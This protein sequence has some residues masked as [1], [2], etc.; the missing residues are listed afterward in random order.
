MFEC[1]R[2]C[3]LCCTFPWDIKVT[4]EEADK[5]AEF[6]KV[7]KESFCGLSKNREGLLCI[8]KKENK[9]CF[10]IENK[11]GVFSCKIYEVRPGECSKYTCEKDIKWL[12][13]YAEFK[14]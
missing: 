7:S 8:N 1:R 11:D 14:E 13:R 4:D 2:N 6:L 3:G 10:F 9:E 5:I 12:K